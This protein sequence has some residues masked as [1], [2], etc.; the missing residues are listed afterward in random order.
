MRRHVRDY[1]AALG[2]STEKDM[3]TT[4]EVLAAACQLERQDL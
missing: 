4:L 1:A 3:R 2:A